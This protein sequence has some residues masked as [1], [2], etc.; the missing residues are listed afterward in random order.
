[1]VAD[2]T[3]PEL[4]AQARAANSMGRPATAEQLLRRAIRTLARDGASVEELQLRGSA[5]VAL[6]SPVFERRGLDPALAVLTEADRLITGPDGDGVRILSLVQRAGFLARGGEWRVAVELLSAI[7]TSS[8]WLSQRQLVSVHLNRATARQYLGDHRSS[9]VDLQ[10]ALELAVAADCP[11]L[12]FKAR[13][14][15]GYS[16]FLTGD[17]P[18]ALATMA[19]ADRMEV[20]VARATAKRDYA[21]VLLESGLTDEAAP[22]LAEALTIA[23]ERRLHQ[24][25][26]EVLVDTARLELLRGRP[27]RALAAASD[28]ARL[29]R[30]RRADGWWAQAEILRAE[31]A[32]AQ[33]T[34]RR[35]ARSM[36]ARLRDLPSE[37]RAVRRDALLVATEA[38][39]AAGDI[40]HARDLFRRTHGTAA[41]PPGRLRQDWLA[42]RLALAAGDRPRARRRLRDAAQRIASLQ[43]RPASLDA[44]TAFALHAQRLVGLDVEIALQTESPQ[45]VLAATERW[46]AA[47]ARLPSLLPHADATLDPL[48]TRLRDLR[49]QLRASP[50]DASTDA[51]TREIE[52]LERQIRRRE[53][54][55]ADH[56]DVRPKRLASAS[57]VA[58][59]A[60]ATDT[61]VISLFATDKR[62]RAVTISADGIR[63]HDLGDAVEVAELSR[64]VLADLGMVR[65]SL[66]GTLPDIVRRSLTRGTDQLA[67]LIPV[68]RTRPHLVLVTTRVLRSAPWRLIPGL[69]DRP[70]VVTPSLTSWLAGNPDLPSTRGVVAL[71]GPGLPRAPLETA[72]VDRAWA[73]RRTVAVSDTATGSDLAAALAGADLVHVAAHGHHHE[74]NALFSSLSMHD[75]PLFAYE[76]QRQGVR[77][78]HVVLSACDIGRAMMR[79]GD[80][81]IGLTATLLACGAR[82]VVAA[83][84][85]V[86]DDAAA[87][88]M[89]AYHRYLASGLPSSVALARATTD[90][91]WPDQ[92]RLFCTYGSNWLASDPTA[93][94]R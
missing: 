64:R 52:D 13:H 6:A 4:I 49:G 16:H 83:V 57:E 54:E 3:A 78:E 33:G 55:L 11:D 81:S 8:P 79:P 73:G 51:L 84:A 7:G 46:R 68:P 58:S 61:D 65:R 80:E 50:G 67:A 26:G 63:L 69:D 19:E 1:M 36:S 20:D 37:S 10:T 25:M 15:L 9:R 90:S 35:S 17:V 18:R 74:Q 48:F 59:H 40:A 31:A 85:P 47:S 32:L 27:G 12:E 82:S 91:P 22:L 44:R 60:A 66:P 62:L 14:N 45:Q 93:A 53:W 86:D 23:T 56:D 28:A 92:A 21:R 87:D 43:G 5:T 42:A 24:E 29:F 75:G 39:L 70:V 89:S 41:S 71:A 77:A 72:A 76:L 38:S 2:N 34:G 94:P 30:R 88:L